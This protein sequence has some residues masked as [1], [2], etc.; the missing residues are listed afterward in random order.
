MAETE[1]VIVTRHQG[2]VEWLRRKGIVGRVVPRAQRQDIFG[3]I[4]YGILP[5]PMAALPKE[6]FYVEIPYMTSSIG[7]AE[8]TADEMT[9]CGALLVPYTVT[10]GN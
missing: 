4:V 8:L 10:R 7:A 2:M 6:F 9:I 1:V 3:K 5:V